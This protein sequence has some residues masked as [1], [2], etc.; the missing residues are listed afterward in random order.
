VNSKLSRKKREWIIKQK[1]KLVLSIILVIVAIF[2]WTRILLVKD[3]KQPV[4][5]T[6]TEEKNN[7]SRKIVNQIRETKDPKGSKQYG[8]KN[9][10]RESPFAK[11]TNSK[12][13]FSYNN[14]IKDNRKNNIHQLNSSNSPFAL[15]GITKKGKS[16]LAVVKVEDRIYLLREGERLEDFMIKKI[17]NKGIILLR[18]KIEYRL[19]IVK[20]RI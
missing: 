11:S 2:L 7:T 12:L 17:E 13:E 16:S 9:S 15:L 5:I 19:D 14:Q 20:Y 6:K 10:K 1:I 3:S 18:D 4:T 8:L